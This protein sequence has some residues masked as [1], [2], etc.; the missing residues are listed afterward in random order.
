[1]V[2]ALTIDIDEEVD[3]EGWAVVTLAGGFTSPIS[4]LVLAATL[5]DL[6]GDGVDTVTVEA[7]GCGRLTSEARRALVVAASQAR[8]SGGCVVAAGLCAQDRAAL[9]RCDVDRLL[10]LSR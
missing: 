9:R 3:R 4:A 6:L 5:R 8:R 1:M 2:A 7:S 10:G